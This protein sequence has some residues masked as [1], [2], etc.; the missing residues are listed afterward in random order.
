MHISFLNPKT[1]FMYHRLQH[2]EILCSAHNAFICF[3]WIS[4]QTAMISLYSINWLVFITDA[5]CLLRGT[6]W[7]FKYNSGYVWIWEQL[8]FPYTALT[9][10]FL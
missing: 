1:Y 5:E 4:E 7:I 3:A 9:D 2:S 6:D 10:W 8:L